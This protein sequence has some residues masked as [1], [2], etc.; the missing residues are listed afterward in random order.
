MFKTILTILAVLFVCL[1]VFMTMDPNLSSNLQN[2]LGNIV[3][4]N[5]NMITVSISGEVLSPGSYVLEKEST[6]ND[7]IVMAGGVSDKADPNAYILSCELKDGQ[8]Y[9]I[10]PL[11][12]SEDICEPVVIDKVNINTATKE[13]LMTVQG[14]GSAIAQAIV[15]YREQNG[16]FTYL[17]QL[18]EV[19]GIGNATFEKIKNYICLS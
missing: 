7:L 17:E 5:Q 2:G 18:L 3:S 4:V 19:A 16:Q 13:E 9:Y 10:A 1:G 6:L 14:I 11:V 12:E 8:N 15:D